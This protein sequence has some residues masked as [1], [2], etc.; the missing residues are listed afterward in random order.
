[1]PDSPPTLKWHSIPPSKT[2]S[3]CQ[4]NLIQAGGLTLP[5]ELVL[6]P[7]PNAPNSSLDDNPPQHEK[8]ETIYVPDFT[9][10]ISP[11]PSNNHYIFDL[12]M[13][14]DL[15][16][17]A[18]TV[19]KNIAK[20]FNCYPKSPADILTRY[21]KEEQKPEHIKAVIFSHLHFDHI[22]DGAKGGFRNAEMW[23]G[24]SAATT[25]RWGYPIDGDGTVLS[26][27]LP[28]DGSRKIVE[29]VL[30]D[31]NVDEK[32]RSAVEDAIKEGKYEGIE[33][34]QPKGGWFP[35]GAFENG[36][37]LFG[38]GSAYVIDA[39]GHSAGHL[40]L[41]LRVKISGPDQ[42]QDDFVMLVGDCF[43]HPELLKDPLLTARPPFSKST[44]H[45]DPD[46]AIDTM[47]RAKR[48]AEEENI[49]VVGAHDF[50][51][52]HVLGNGKEGVE[53]LVCLNDWRDRGW[54][55]A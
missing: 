25:A 49:W 34:R 24:P 4:V 44:M 48:C 26:E 11:T 5:K 21:G 35:L 2:G 6:L 12:G 42:G 7:S 8:R 53:G 3:T 29:F 20:N 10:L 50:S 41:L 47:L 18:P 54:K 30:P 46:V 15:H 43:H 27:D 51:V 45:S 17:S 33:R 19:L 32:R 38:D 36:F 13:R 16:N 39:P 23:L 31:E 37:D 14:K 55:K 28:W 52:V 22:G 40:M 9:F 1:M